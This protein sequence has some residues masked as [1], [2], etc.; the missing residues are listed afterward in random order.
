[1]T[2]MFSLSTSESER[3]MRSLSPTGKLPQESIQ[4]KECN[5]CGKQVLD[6]GVEFRDG[7]SCREWYISGTCQ[8]CQDHLFGGGKDIE[9]E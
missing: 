6:I 3:F 5:I 4:D 2:E 9:V 1:M 7:L 8:G